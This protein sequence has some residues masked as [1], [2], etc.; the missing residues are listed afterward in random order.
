MNDSAE[1]PAE[2]HGRQLRRGIVRLGLFAAVVVVIIVAVPGLG[3]IRSRLA[4]GDPAWLVVAGLLRLASALSYVVT[5][6]AVFAPRMSR[7]LSYRIAMSEVGLNALVPAG[8]A[9]GLAIGG[10]LL[11]RRG[12]PTARVLERS[13]EFFVFTSAFNVGA[14]AVFGWLGT[15]G[16]LATH[17]S[18]LLSLVPALV[19]SALIAA[20]L[21][22]IPR[23]GSLQARQ[24]NQ[25]T[26]SWCWWVLDGVVMLGTGARGALN[27]FRERDP[28]ALFG[29]AG[30]LLFDIATLW[31][32][33]RAFHGDPVLPALVM[34]YLVGQLAGEVPI[35]GG[36][37]VVDGGLIG[38]LILYGFPVTLATT[39]SL[40]Y[41]AIALAVP[42]LFGG[43]A[44][45]LLTRC[46][47][48]TNRQPTA[49]VISDQLGPPG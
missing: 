38:A 49:Q 31:A 34:A 21:A 10:W 48:G 24:R 26:H 22:A 41:R 20:A 30:Y 40:A 2:L 32:A 43:L 11:H 3:S 39:G 36:I 16:V 44:A 15:A 18:L 13:A 33:V 23:I 5:F 28:R 4:H 35:P 47:R 27:L 37:G 19:A 8:G 12:M 1:L 45:F 7:R 29:G 6:R 17:A 14:V 46:V 25:R 9:G 42:T